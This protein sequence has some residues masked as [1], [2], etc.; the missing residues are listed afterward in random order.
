M[1]GVYEQR[2]SALDVANIVAR[3]NP[4]SEVW[5]YDADGASRLI[6][7]YSDEPPDGDAGEDG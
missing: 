2:D 4:P 7:T 3:A 1:L 5:L 6:A